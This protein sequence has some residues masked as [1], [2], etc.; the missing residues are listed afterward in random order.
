MVNSKPRH[1]YDL[2][3]QVKFFLTHKPHVFKENTGHRPMISANNWDVDSVILEFL[4]FFFQEN[5]PIEK[6]SPTKYSDV[7]VIN[8]RR[9]SATNDFKICVVITLWC[10]SI[11]LETARW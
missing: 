4:A 9:N 5:T 3:P 6:A 2:V 1:S 7:M 11:H 10:K 8:D